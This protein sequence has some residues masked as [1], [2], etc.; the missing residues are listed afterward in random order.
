[1][2]HQLA[3]RNE[4]EVLHKCL[5]KT[6]CDIIDRTSSINITNTFVENLPLVV[7]KLKL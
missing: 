6:N 5:R 7:T 3:N 4:R 1:M 2:L